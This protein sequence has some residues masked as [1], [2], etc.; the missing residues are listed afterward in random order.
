MEYINNPMAMDF[1]INDFA[2]ASRGGYRE[3]K[4]CLEWTDI[5]TKVQ[6]GALPGF[7]EPGWNV[8][9]DDAHNLIWYSVSRIQISSRFV[10][11]LNLIIIREILE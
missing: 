1:G 4:P 7:T 5:T 9:V 8:C 11:E 3:S 10:Y 6:K 2:W